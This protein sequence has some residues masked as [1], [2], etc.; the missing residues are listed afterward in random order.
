MVRGSSMR[1]TTLAILALVGVFAFAHVGEASAVLFND[2]ADFNAAVSDYQ[3][4]TYFDVAGVNPGFVAF[5][6]YNGIEFRGDVSFAIFGSTLGATSPPLTNQLFVSLTEPVTAVGFDLVQSSY[7]N[8]FLQFFPNNVNFSFST[9][10]GLA[11]TAS[12]APQSFF[13]VLLLDDM[14]ASMSFRAAPAGCACTTSFAMDNLA[15]QSVPEPSTM[16]LAVVGCATVLGLRRR[17]RRRSF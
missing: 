5:G 3:L 14:F 6:N 10:G 13:G 12:L 8:D 11:S 15:V 1:R 4:F 9:A 17:S 7:T 16:A 2:R